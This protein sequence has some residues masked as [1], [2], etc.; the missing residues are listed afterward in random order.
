MKRALGLIAV[1]GMIGGGFVPEELSARPVPI[2]VRSTFRLGS[3]GVICSAQVVPRDPRLSGMFDRGYTISCRDAAGPVG[4]LVALR[5]AAPID[6]APV[7]GVPATAGPQRAC[8]AAG[9]VEIAALGS[10]E[11]MICR[12][13]ASGLDYRRYALV[14]GDTSYFV[15]GLAA[16]DAALRLALASVVLNKAVPGEITV[17]TTEVT[18]AAAF[19]RLQAGLLDPLGVRGE[20]YL[21]N[22]GS[23]FAESAAF[24]EVLAEKARGLKG[25]RAEMAEALANEGLQQSNLG[26]F[27]VAVRLFGESERAQLSGDGLSQRLLRNYRALD[28]LNQRRAHAAA[29]ELARPVDPVNAIFNG[30]MLAEGEINLPLS[31]AINR[32]N[33][34][35]RRMG[36]P[37]PALSRAEKAEILDGQALAIGATAARM[38]GRTEEATAGFA[39]ARERLGAVRGGQVGSIVWLTAEIDIEMAR[40]A[41]AAGRKGEAEAGFNRAIAALEAAYPASPAV[42]SAKARKAAFLLAAGDRSEAAKL[43][44]A[45]VEES[46]SIPDSGTTLRDLLAPY[47]GL[48]VGE[49]GDPAS[50]AAAAFAAAQVLERPG[51]AQTQAILARQLAEGNDAAA[52]LFRLSLAR[53]R[54]IARAEGEV[55]R[56]G[57]LANPTA[58]ETAEL[59]TQQETLNALRREQTELL[60]KLAAYPRYTALAPKRVAL[61][62][63][64]AALKP[65]E[66]YY[67]LVA[68]GQ[69]LYGLYATAGSARLYAVPLSRSTLAREVQ[70]IRDS[71]VTIENGRA[72]NRPFDL[73]RSRSLYKALFGPVD[74]E[75]AGVRHLVFEPD[76]AMLQLPP[77]VLVTADAGIAAYKA[78]TVDIDADAFDFT[79]IAWFG[80]GRAISIAVSPRAFLDLRVLAPS[81]ARRPY[82]GLG[83]NSVPQQRPVTAVA[84]SCDWPLAVWQRPV[85]PEELLFAAKKL[86]SMSVVKTG[87]SFTDAGLL[88]D[89]SLDQYR[90]LHFATHGL[91]SA[92]RKDCPARPALVTSFAAKGSDGLLSFREIFDLK[93]D[94]D[95]VILSACDTAGMAT[96]AASREAGVTT[97]GNYALDGLVR[98]FTGAGARAVIA[99]HWPVPDD[100]DATRRL[101]GGLIAG[102]SSDSVGQALAGAEAALMDDPQTSHPFYWAAFVVVGDAAKPAVAAVAVR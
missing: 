32:E 55:A 43:F 7:V 76:A 80:R 29:A 41:G 21:R 5:H 31:E 30:E 19:A 3:A 53:G 65:G 26:N 88:A 51:V 85:K 75:L 16:Y 8:G 70:K 34:A 15:E 17:A 13:P 45:V 20:G 48:L 83:N 64:Q 84:D 14:R 73:E 94:A 98:A 56:L 82:L 62:E 54:D 18:D 66:A 36:A 78:R 40:I 101:I 12:D 69:D 61:A 86:G 68:V 2:S 95:L 27:D 28:Q 6:A 97:G 87:T 99:S 52:A 96:V 1:L 72:V 23:S 10:A 50:R 25:E 90:V 57:G 9:R 74:A 35:A 38:A 79:G 67:K 63:M 4:T 11:A 37:D 39:K 77:A 89:P 93:L 47:F 60:A 92:P 59:G 42:L 100:F 58:A 24:F 44:G 49:G 71:I 81:T 102:K 46:A 33:S 22:N 91:V